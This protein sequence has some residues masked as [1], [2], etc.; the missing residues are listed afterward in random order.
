MTG[1]P[2][3]AD[4]QLEGIQGGAGQNYT[5]LVTNLSNGCQNSAVVNVADEK[6]L[7]ELRLVATDNT[8]CDPALTSPAVQF[9]GT[10]TATVDNMVGVIDDYTF[11]FGGGAGVAGAS[12]NHNTF[13]QL[14]GG[15]TYDA[16]ATHTPTGCVS[17]PATVQVLNNHDIPE[18]TTSSTGS[19]NTSARSGR[20][21]C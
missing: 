15:I 11:V 4:I 16:T 17:T 20:R 2:T 6:I 1:N 9:N 7:P 18:L 14:N 21:C 8:V 10:V 19:T 5:A 3:N 12:P 13:T